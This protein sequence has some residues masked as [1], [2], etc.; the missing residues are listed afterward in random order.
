MQGLDSLIMWPMRQYLRYLRVAFSVACAVA[1][2]LLV[3]LWVRSYQART[4]MEVLVTPWSRFE[5]HSLDGRL[6]VLKRDR[7]FWSLEMMLAYPAD[8]FS[9]LTKPST[10]GFRWYSDGVFSA[11]SI[12]YCMLT[13]LCATIAT[14]LWLPWSCRFSLRT[15]LIATTLLAFLLGLTEVFS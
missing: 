13:F 1:C 14:V 6:I 12:T 2:V 15:L 4:S 7:V 10:C 3:P 9:E 8:L 11:L 5:A